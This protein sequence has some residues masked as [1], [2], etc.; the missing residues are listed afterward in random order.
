[1]NELKKIIFELYESN[2]NILK[3]SSVSSSH[4]DKYTKKLSVTKIN[5]EYNILSYGIAEFTNKNIYSIIKSIP[6]K[7]FLFYLYIKYFKKIY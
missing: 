7:L 5:N 4:W 3:K 2:F 6:R 1:M